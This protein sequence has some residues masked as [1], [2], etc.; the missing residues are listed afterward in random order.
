MGQQQL[1]RQRT[2]ANSF[3]YGDASPFAQAHRMKQKLR[4]KA[5]GRARGTG[6]GVGG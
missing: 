1:E 5:P 4:T 3:A 2:E 6:T